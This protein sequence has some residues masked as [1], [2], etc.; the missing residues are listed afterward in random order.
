MVAGHRYPAGTYTI[1]PWADRV[2]RD[3]LGAPLAQADEAHPLWGYLAAQNGIG[4]DIEG[5]MAPVDAR[6]QDGTMIAS[7]EVEFLRDL[8]VGVTY[9]VTGEIVGLERKVGRRTGPFDLFTFFI[10]LSDGDAHVVR[11]T[12][13]FVLPRREPADVPA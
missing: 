11:M 4:I 1:A 5:L 9:D 3:T 6:P 12:A 8:R 13:V 10:D 7:C 2:L